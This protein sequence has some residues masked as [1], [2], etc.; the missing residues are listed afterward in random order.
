M[1]STFRISA[2]KLAKKESAIKQNT[3][4]VEG[5]LY[6]L[7][8]VRAGGKK[9]SVQDGGGGGSTEGGSAGGADE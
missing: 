7:S 8:V 5:L 6:D 3:R 9:A 2:G 1:H 4:K